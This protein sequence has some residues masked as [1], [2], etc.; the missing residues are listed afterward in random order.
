MNNTIKEICDYLHNYF[1]GERK[2]GTFTIENG[3][4]DVS[5]I[6][7]LDGQYIRIQGSIFND[8]IYQ[9][10]TSDL[11][12]ESF[13]G[14]VSL[15]KIPSDVLSIAAEIDEWKAKNAQA[16]VSPFQ[17]ESFGGYSYSKAS[18]GAKS[19]G[20]QITWKDIF[21]NRLDCYRKLP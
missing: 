8:G 21:G 18:G 13:S 4:L 1:V 11:K 19:G 15:L 7:V 16:L 20:G 5:D 2:D 10:P 9:H 12:N 14:A 3:S 17:S 6:P